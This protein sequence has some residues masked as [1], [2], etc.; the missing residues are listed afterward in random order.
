MMAAT[1]DVLLS[2]TGLDAGYHGQPIVRGLDMKLRAGE[3]VGLF[4]ANGAGKTTSLMTLAG[5]QRPLAGTVSLSGAPHPGSLY[6]AARVGLALL[7]DDRGIFAPLTVRDNLRLGQGR[8]EDALAHFPE[9]GDHLDRRAGLLSGGQ[10][11]MLAVAR[12]LASRPKVVLADELSLGLAPLIVRRLLSALRA[13][14]DEGATVLIV[15]QHV[16]VALAMVDRA[17]VLAHGRVALEQDAASLRA[18]PEAITDLYL[19]AA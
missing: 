7:T 10:Q 2:A 19:A 3:M 16:P 5:V 11:Q 18:T 12:I 1:D 4:G 9:L 8:V 17:I 15:E 13:A 14:A 6:K